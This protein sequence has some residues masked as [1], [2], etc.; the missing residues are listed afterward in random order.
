MRYLGIDIT[1]DSSD[2]FSWVSRVLFF[3]K[4]KRVK[5]LESPTWFYKHNALVWLLIASSGSTSVPWLTQ[6]FKWMNH[7]SPP[8]HYRCVISNRECFE[9]YSTQLSVM[10]KRRIREEGALRPWRAPQTPKAMRVS[11]SCRQYLSREALVLTRGK[12][13]SP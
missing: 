11:S 10:C 4:A 5:Y 2:F 6:Y 7:V 12:I 9:C 1:V 3:C 8:D 13:R